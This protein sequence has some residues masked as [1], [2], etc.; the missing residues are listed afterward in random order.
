[1]M[2]NVGVL[3]AVVR[4]TLGVALLA[5]SYGRIGPGLPET[6]AWIAWIAGA[7]FAATGIFRYCPLYAWAG[8]NSCAPYPGDDRD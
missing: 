7:V 5:W 2:T 4:L 6:P 3:D 1:M 8:T